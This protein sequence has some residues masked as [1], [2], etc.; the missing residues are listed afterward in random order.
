MFLAARTMM[1]ASDQPGQ[2]AM[3][4]ALLSERQFRLA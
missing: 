2:R 1:R 3:A 4:D